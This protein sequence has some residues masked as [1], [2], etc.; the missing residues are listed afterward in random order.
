MKSTIAEAKILGKYVHKNILSLQ[1]FDK[2]SL[3]LLFKTTNH[4]IEK[5]KH[6]KC[7]QTLAG[8]IITLLFFEPS[9]RTFSS[10]SSAIK[11]LGGQTIEYQNPMQTSSSAKGESLNDTIRVFESYSDLIIMRHHMVGMA[12]KAA[13]AA[14]YVPIINAG[15]GVGE[16]PTQALLDLFTINEKFGTLN[17]L[18]GLIAGD[19]LNGR[20]AHSLM[21]GFSL[22][23]NIT[24]YLLSPQSLSLRREFLNEFTTITIK[25]IHSEKEI[26]KNCDF[27]YWTR[28]QKERFS[29]LKE[30][31]KVKDSF[32]LTKKL[33]T[34][35]GN[36][37]MIIMH[38][39]P[40]INEI[41]P[42]ID[43]DPRAYYF[44]QVRN[45]LFV[46]MALL[47]LVLG[48]S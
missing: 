46:R 14:R 38:P 19:L 47:S 29:D 26:P 1:Q 3:E 25:E 35:K 6:N 7:P 10:F 45:G 44:K 22:Y 31:V 37:N 40:R 23:K 41:D 33:L 12:K 36:K 16:H 21:R 28:I 30:Y 13:E 34:D 2:K 39:L 20:T 43:D 4:I 18:T 32:I 5:C 11:R 48:G 24:L 17:G 42:E 27:W 8:N 15:D 9:S